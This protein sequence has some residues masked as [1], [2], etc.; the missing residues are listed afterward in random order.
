MKQINNAEAR[1]FAESKVWQNHSKAVERQYNNK[2][3]I[4]GDTTIQKLLA[5]SNALVPEIAIKRYKGGD[6]SGLVL[7]QAEVCAAIK[8]GLAGY[9]MELC[10]IQLC[11]TC[12]KCGDTGKVATGDCE[13]FKGYVFEYIA[14]RLSAGDDVDFAS[15]K[16]FAKGYPEL[17]KFYDYAEKFCEK[18][19]EVTKKVLILK[20]EVGT[21]KSHLAKG[22][23]GK[24]IAK[25]ASG[26][27]VSAFNMEE[28]FVKNLLNATSF[29]PNQTVADEHNIL[30]NADVLVVDDLGAEI[31]H[32]EKVKPY[33]INLMETRISNGK[34]TIFT[35]NLSDNAIKERYG[36]RFFSRLTSK[37]T[38]V[39]N[40][41][42]GEDL[43]KKAKL[44]SSSE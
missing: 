18:Y 7:E 44:F 21:G 13:C 16:E 42:T 3:K 29:N 43:R 38:V 24:L 37:A 31:V 1:L 34:L 39:M 8:A 19:P 40:V 2:A 32:T 27:F 22:M 41:E 12:E 14:G 26:L 35:T 33:Y 10:D 11:P 4:N 30:M 36:E 28:V 17:W 5:R 23:L 9:G 25:G 6:V 20:G 15:S